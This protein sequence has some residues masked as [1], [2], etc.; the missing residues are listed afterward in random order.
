MGGGGGGGREKRKEIKE[1]V[2]HKMDGKEVKEG[3]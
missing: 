2:E 3:I 1:K